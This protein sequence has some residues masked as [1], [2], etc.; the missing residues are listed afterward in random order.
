MARVDVG[1]MGMGAKR[2]S[3]KPVQ[4]GRHAAPTT[5]PAHESGSSLFEMLPG[6]FLSAWLILT[7]FAYWRLADHPMVPTTAAVPGL[8]EA[9]QASRALLVLIGVAAIIEHLRRRARSRRPAGKS[10]AER[11]PE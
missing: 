11:E 2:V 1:G 8:S 10:D 6:V 4:A 5:E 7:L 9:D 3:R